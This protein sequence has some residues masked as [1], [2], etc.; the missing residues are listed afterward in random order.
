LRAEQRGKSEGEYEGEKVRKLEGVR[1]WGNVERRES[2]KV[3][4]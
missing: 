4:R 3:Q 1:V 2:E